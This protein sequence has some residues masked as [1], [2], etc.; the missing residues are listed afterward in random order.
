MS[1]KSHDAPRAIPLARERLKLS[2]RRVD[3]A[4]VMV[5]TTTQVDPVVVDETLDADEV[6]IERTPI[7]RFVDKPPAPRHEGDTLV[8]PVLEEVLVVT[9]RLRVVEEI[10]IRRRVVTRRHQETVELRRQRLDVE[11]RPPGGAAEKRT[12]RNL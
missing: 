12:K 6:T 2:R 9:R 11:R 8:I 3:A 10:R 7:D 4:R 1:S 5:K